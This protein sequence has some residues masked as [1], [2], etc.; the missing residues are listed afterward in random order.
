MLDRSRL[1]NILAIAVPITFGLLSQT[2]MNLVDTSM[3]RDSGNAALAAVGIA[4]FANFMAGAPI[5]GLSAGVQ[6]LCARRVGE[7]R[8]TESALPLNGGLAVCIGFGV[9]WV[10][11]IAL[12]APVWFPRL[13]GS[14]EIAAVGLPYLYCRLAATVLVGMH[15]SFR[16]FWNATGRSTFYMI[17]LLVMHSLNVVLDWV[18]I[19]GCSSTA[20]SARRASVSRAPVWRVP[21]QHPPGWACTSTWRC[22]TRV[23]RASCASCRAASSSPTC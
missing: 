22:A 12:L 18:L 14:P 19:Y 6:A 9:P 8:P 21:S 5:M 13:A 2:V 15:F 17:N 16:A 1:A 7:N 4:S 10:L 11:V 20:S 3:V 23:D